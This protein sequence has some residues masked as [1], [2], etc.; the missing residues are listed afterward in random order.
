MDGLKELE[1]QCAKDS[2][3]V[4][5]EGKAC[6]GLHAQGVVRYMA[7]EAGLH[8]QVGGVLPVAASTGGK[9]RTAGTELYV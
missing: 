3:A 9:W 6:Q 1:I 2:D 4:S 5:V 8:A 7:A